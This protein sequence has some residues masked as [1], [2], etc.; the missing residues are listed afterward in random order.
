[1]KDEA[2]SGIATKEVL[3]DIGDLIDHIGVGAGA[4]HD[5]ETYEIL[6]VTTA[7]QNNQVGYRVQFDGFIHSWNSSQ[8]AYGI[9]VDVDVPTT[10]AATAGC[11]QGYIWC[12]PNTAGIANVAPTLTNAKFPIKAGQVINVR[13][14]AATQLFLRMWLARWIH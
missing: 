9:A 12:P 4:V 3:A 5:Y 6:F 14:L 2:P 11:Y 1:M 8:S 13:T 7:A 10:L